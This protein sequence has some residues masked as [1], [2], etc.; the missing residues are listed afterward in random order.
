[1]DAFLNQPTEYLH[2]YWTRGIPK[3]MHMRFNYPM[4]EKAEGGYPLPFDS[5]ALTRKAQ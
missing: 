3:Q 1:M 2:T 5:F 4:T